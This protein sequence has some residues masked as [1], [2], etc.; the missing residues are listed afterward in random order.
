[1]TMR[2]NGLCPAFLLSGVVMGLILC[3][4][5]VGSGTRPGIQRMIHPGLP[6]AIAPRR[7]RATSQWIG[8]PVP[9]DFSL[10]TLSRGRWRPL[11]GKPAVINILDH[12][13]GFSESLW[14]NPKSI[15]GLIEELAAGDST[16]AL[17]ADLVFVSRGETAKGDVISLSNS[18][19]LTM[20]RMGISTPRRPR[21]L[22]LPSATHHKNSR[23]GDAPQHPPRSSDPCPLSIYLQGGVALQAAL[24]DRPGRKPRRGIVAAGTTSHQPDDSCFYHSW[25]LHNKQVRR[26]V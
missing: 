14:Y 2:V 10:P 5:P 16:R 3:G 18:I 1:M 15:E 23:P 6:I 11:L 17:P 8:S 9:P 20:V 26:E 19:E 25:K 24:R 22:L 12:S 7:S 13:N 4:L 21:C